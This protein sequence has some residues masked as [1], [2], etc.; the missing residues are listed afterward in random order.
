MVNWLVV[1][2]L[3]SPAA[4]LDL[5]ISFITNHYPM[6][7]YLPTTTSK[8]G[9]MFTLIVYYMLTSLISHLHLRR[10]KMPSSWLGNN[11]TF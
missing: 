10:T 2:A 7:A 1:I 3:T 5:N 11:G 8:Q 6:C 4:N 9:R